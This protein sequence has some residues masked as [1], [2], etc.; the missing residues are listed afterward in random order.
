[1]KNISRARRAQSSMES[2][3]ALAL[4]AIA[5]IG[6]WLLYKDAIVQTTR[7]MFEKLTSVDSGS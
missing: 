3:V 1:M 7:V 2:I 6:A 5:S 4:F